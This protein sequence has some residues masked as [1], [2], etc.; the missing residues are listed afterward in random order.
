[1]YVTNGLLKLMLVW[2]TYLTILSGL[3]GSEELFIFG[4][5]VIWDADEDV[6][7]RFCFAC[8]ECVKICPTVNSPTC[9]YFMPS[10][11]A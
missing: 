7:L 4:L 2:V 1:M 8:V 6:G 9:N 10:E 5:T 11:G 3:R